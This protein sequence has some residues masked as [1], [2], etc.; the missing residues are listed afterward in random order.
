M[1]MV[2]SAPLKIPADP[3]TERAQSVMK[4]TEVG[5]IADRREPNSKMRAARGP[6]LS[7]MVHRSCRKTEIRAAVGRL[8]AEP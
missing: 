3:A 6:A 8:K 5:A 2:T 7:S 4:T 1:V